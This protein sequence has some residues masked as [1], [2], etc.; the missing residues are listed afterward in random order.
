M[1][2][3]ERTD[4]RPFVSVEP[5]SAEWTK[6]AMQPPAAAS[7]LS[8][9]AVDTIAVARAQARVR[10]TRVL[11][12]A[13]AWGRA[14]TPTS[15]D[16]LPDFVIIGA[17]RC[18]T[19]S[20]YDVLGR[21]LQV[22]RPLL[23]EVQFFTLHFGRGMRWYRSCFPDVPTGGQTFDASPYYIFDPAVPAR[24]AAALPD[25]KFVLLIR[26]PVAR[27]LSHYRHSRYLGQERLSFDAAVA[28][29]NER[30]ATARG[31]SESANHHALRAY[32]YLSR[33][34]YAEQLERWYEHVSPD[35]IA[36][37]ASEELF[38][39]PEQTLGDLLRFLELDPMPA[40][41]FPSTNAHRNQD[42][43]SLSPRLRAQ[44]DD[45][46]APHNERLAQ[47]LGWRPAWCQPSPTSTGADRASTTS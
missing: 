36:V 45:Y 1:L 23:K 26:D 14:W 19:T 4:G 7:S 15:R 28:A 18:G 21:H 34:R 13:R 31:R 2:F 5:T 33:G 30:L 29:E 43:E 9:F 27:A 20:L 39:D 41:A 47:L 44:L 32:S 40:P 8:T 42:R 25:A 22:R 24:V 16:Q 12:S 10:G 3:V 37:V 6:G 46:F 17:Q 35:R 11:R 38:A